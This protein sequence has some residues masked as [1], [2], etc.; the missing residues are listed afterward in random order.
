MQFV[1]CPASR[2]HHILASM[3]LWPGIAVSNNNMAFA[4]SACT[5]QAILQQC[6]DQLAMP[7]HT[8]L[9]MHAGLSEQHR[10]NRLPCILNCVCAC[11]RAT[12]EETRH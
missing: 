10:Y 11:N 3:Q 4:Q 7:G 2:V 6:S 12:V 8:M 5:R 9:V 1:Q